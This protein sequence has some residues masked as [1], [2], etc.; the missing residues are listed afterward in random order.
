MLLVFALLAGGCASPESRIKRAPEAFAR[1][2]LEHQELVKEGKVALG[3]DADAVRLAVGE[4]DRIWR[5]TDESGVTTLWS[6]TN[7]ADGRGGLL[8][9]GWYH[10][11]AGLYPYYLDDPSRR[12]VEYFKVVF[13]PDGKVIGIEQDGR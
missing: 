8:Y 10:H 2:S 3:F 7:W 13:G 9:R 12:E 4:P 6:Y 11:A 5:R 1:L